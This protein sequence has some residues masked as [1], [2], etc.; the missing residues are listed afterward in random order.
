MI[1]LLAAS[2]ASRLD[3]PPRRTA[4]TET[5]LHQPRE[6]GES[7]RDPHEDEDRYADLCANVEFSHASN[8]IAENDE[9]DGCDDGRDGDDESVEEGEDGDGEGE[10]AREDRERHEED[11]HKG[12]AGACEEE[13]E[14]KLRDVFDE[15]EDV[16]DVGGEVD[17]NEVLV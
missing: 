11:E 4:A 8:S 15:V 10:P 6:N 9:H 17:C 3:I 13:T 14:H 16:V 7:A 12:E 5:C 1:R 2:L